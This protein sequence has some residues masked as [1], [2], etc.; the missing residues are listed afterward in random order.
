MDTY[1]APAI[2]TERRK[3]KNQISD[4]SH[5]PIMSNLLKVTN[6]LLV[7]LNEDRQIVALNH[8]FMDS[9]GIK[10]PQ[11]ALGLRLGES[12]HCVHSAEQ[13]NGCGTTPY[14]GTCGAAIAMMTA[15]DKNIADEQICALTAGQDGVTKDA[16]LLIKAQ[17]LSLDENR[18][19]LVYAQDI[20]QQ[21]Y[22]VNLERI[23]FHD[24][25]NVLSSIMGNSELLAMEFPQLKKVQQ[26]KK[27]AIRLDS[28]ISLQSSLSQRKESHY[29]ARK[30]ETSI[31][32][33]RQE[34]DLIVSGHRSAKNKD[35]VEV[36]PSEDKCI[37]TDSM[38]VS[39]ILGNMVINALEATIDG[40]AIKLTT[41]LETALVTWEVWNKCYIPDDIQKRIFQRHFSTKSDMGRGLGTYSMK[42]FGE[43]YLGGEVTFVST[44]A[45]GTIFRFCLPII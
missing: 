32:S 25:K 17:P 45:E 40:G 19:I 23:F 33:I 31:S 13:P 12:L 15:I 43:T 34:V 38:L 42:L 18:W 36:W 7:I 20:T 10:D 6:G 1:F 44:E 29:L 14:C 9:L 16:C 2:R 35:F 26:I 21:Q 28:E 3:L 4:I 27:A 24:M 30:E 11:K 41:K 39:R 37:F 22:W 5:N 8:A